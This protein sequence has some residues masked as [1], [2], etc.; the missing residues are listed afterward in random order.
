MAVRQDADNC[1]HGHVIRRYLRTYQNEADTLD[2]LILS[3]EF[4]LISS[5]LSIP[6]YDRRMTVARAKE[7]HRQVLDAL[8]V[9]RLYP[10]SPSSPH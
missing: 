2:I 7:L 1:V 9:G 10:L 4:G 3:A 5:N 6:Y 8:R